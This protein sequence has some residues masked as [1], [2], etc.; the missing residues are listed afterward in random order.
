MSA[1]YNL[2]LRNWCN[3][4]ASEEQIDLAAT[5]GLITEDEAVKI[6]ETPQNSPA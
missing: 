3:C 6:K 5:K 1:I 2:F 4:R